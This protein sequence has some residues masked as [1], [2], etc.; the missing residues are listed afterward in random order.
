MEDYLD[1]I[2]QILSAVQDASTN[3]DASSLEEVDRI[4]LGLTTSSAALGEL[5][6]SILPRGEYEGVLEDRALSQLRELHL[7]QSQVENKH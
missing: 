5:L 3:S 2:G 4:H 1:V 7:W 6:N